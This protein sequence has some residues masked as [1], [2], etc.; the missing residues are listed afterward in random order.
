MQKPNRIKPILCVWTGENFVPLPR[1]MRLCD[2]Q[3]EVNEEYPLIP[4]EERSM[5]SHR[6]YFA[7]VKEAWKNLDEE[8]DGRFPTEEHLRSWA[9]VQ[10]GYAT[11]SNFILDSDKQ[12]LNL[13]VSLRRRS[14]LSVIRVSGNVVQCF[15][16]ES[17]SVHAMKRER[18]EASKKAVLELVSSM[19][20]TTPSE[21]RK[22]A[23]RSS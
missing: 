18:F 16:P 6:G 21:L 1:F 15:D 7:Q 12:A 9:L 8:F 23:G 5:N 13:A 10:T 22:N 3:F 17:Q 14:P 11:E 2:Q 20:R 19:A 4:S